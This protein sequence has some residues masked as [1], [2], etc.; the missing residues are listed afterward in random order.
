MTLKPAAYRAP[1]R[2]LAHV[3]GPRVGERGVVCAAGPFAGPGRTCRGEAH[4]VSGRPEPTPV[5]ILVG[6][7]I[8]QAETLKA[9]V[10][11]GSP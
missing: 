7:A 2:A 9:E 8:I 1:G 6:V 3:R 4:R 10:E 11:K 5:Q